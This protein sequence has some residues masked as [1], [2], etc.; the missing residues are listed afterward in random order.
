M[1]I[2]KGLELLGGIV[3]I[4]SSLAG[5]LQLVINNCVIS[6]VTSHFPNR[7]RKRLPRSFLVAV[8]TPDSSARISRYA[9]SSGC[10][11][12]Y[13]LS[14]AGV[15]AH[16]SLLQQSAHTHPD[17][18]HPGVKVLNN[19]FQRTGFFFL[20]DRTEKIWCGLHIALRAWKDFKVCLC[21]NL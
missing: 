8:P 20:N 9:V 11:G 12:R 3:S 2:Q 1:L 17:V 16:L 21:L 14:T 19:I 4:S 15:D 5:S 7:S 18:L 10:R 6:E 13:P